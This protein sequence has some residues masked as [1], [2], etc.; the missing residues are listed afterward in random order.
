VGAREQST[1]GGCAS[2]KTHLASPRM[3]HHLVCGHPLVFRKHAGL[4]AGR[5]VKAAS[6]L[7]VS[8]RCHDGQLRQDVAS[9][10]S[11]RCD[12]A[13]GGERGVDPG[14][15]WRDM[16]ERKINNDRG[17]TRGRNPRRYGCAGFDELLI[18]V[19][20]SDKRW[21]FCYGVGH[22]ISQRSAT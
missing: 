4:A 2:P 14:R 22:G 6:S 20:Y 9:C 5:D 15:A 1:N 12:R 16:Q 7:H 18:P 8:D 17:R 3:H 19:K 10:R 13:G 11:E 21:G